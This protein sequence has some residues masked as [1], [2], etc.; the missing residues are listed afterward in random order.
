[1]NDL[2]LLPDWGIGEIALVVVAALLFALAL[3][4]GRWPL[5][6]IGYL[7]VFAALILALAAGSAHHARQLGPGALPP[8]MAQPFAGSGVL[9]DATRSAQLATRT[10]S[11]S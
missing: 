4:S 8:I 9:D 11:P 6:L 10:V 7:A 1:M 5:W 3:V 2:A